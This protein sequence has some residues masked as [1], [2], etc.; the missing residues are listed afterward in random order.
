MLIIYEDRFIL[1]ALYFTRF[2]MKERNPLIMGKNCIFEVLRKSPRRII[3]VY[4]SEGSKNDP[5]Y[6]SLLKHKVPIV[7]LNKQELSQIADSSS[8]QSFVAACKP[9]EFLNLQRFLEISEGSDKSLVLMLDSIVDP[10]NFGAILRAAEC[11]GIDC[12][13]FSKNRGTDLTPVVS[14]VSSGASELISLIKVSNLAETVSSFQRQ[15]FSVLAADVG[16]R[17]QSIYEFS[18]PD[19]TLLILGSEGEG[20]QPLL[21]K[22]SDAIVK[23]PM[24]G[25][26][27]SLNVSQAASVFL[28][29]WRLQHGR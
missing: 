12:V 11:F 6:L 28:F 7:H 14:K 4:T 13:V 10:H 2:V 18:F 5:L 1:L 8:H 24:L 3:K 21:K 20:V 25:A 29:A 26:I 9:R 19:K 23:V 16:E 27:D 22:K 15:G 17:A